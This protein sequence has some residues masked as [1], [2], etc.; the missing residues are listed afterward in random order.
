MNAS[1]R[2]A[3]FISYAN[4]DRTFARRLHR[5]LEAYHIPAAI[6]PVHLTDDLRSRNRLYPVFRDRE[7]LPSGPLGEAIE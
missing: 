6:G 5:A 2:Y 7:E 1:Y 3:A 4:A